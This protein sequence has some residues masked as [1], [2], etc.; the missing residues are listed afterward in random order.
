MGQGIENLNKQSSAGEVTSSTASVSRAIDESPMLGRPSKD[1]SRNP[2]IV[3]ERMGEN[4]SQPEN[5]K[6]HRRTKISLYV[7]KKFSI[8][9]SRAKERRMVKCGSLHSK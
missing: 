6:G 4:D 7:G 1:A 3:K 5:Q 2:G 9:A 8:H